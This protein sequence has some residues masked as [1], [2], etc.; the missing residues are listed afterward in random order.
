[1][2]TRPRLHH[3]IGN[4]NPLAQNLNYVD[5]EAVTQL[6]TQAAD[7]G[8]GLNGLMNSLRSE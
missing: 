6:L 1:M 8:R 2:Q 7:I 3:G 5:G 4:A